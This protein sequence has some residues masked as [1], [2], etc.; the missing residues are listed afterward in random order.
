MAG[1]RIRITVPEICRRLELGPRAV[2]QM[3]EQHII[4]AIRLRHRWIITRHAYEEWEKQ[5]GTDVARQRYNS[6]A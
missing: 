5:C 2:Y 4:P 3:L 1:E 6:P